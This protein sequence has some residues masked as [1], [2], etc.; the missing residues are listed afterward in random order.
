MTTLTLDTLAY[1]NALQKAGLSKD[2]AE[3]IVNAN[4]D[5]LKNMVATQELATKKDVEVIV[6]KAQH[7]TLK[8]VMG[9]MIAQTTLI[10]TAFGIGIAI[11]K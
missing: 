2:Q 8:W 5:A 3:A 4:A 10:L 1:S 7:E 11:L 9:L 6:S